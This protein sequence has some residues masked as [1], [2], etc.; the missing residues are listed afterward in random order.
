MIRKSYPLCGGGDGN[1]Y[2]PFAEY[3]Y[4]KLSDSG[5]CALVLPTGIV[6][7]KTYS[8]FISKLLTERRLISVYGFNSKSRIFKSISM[9]FCVL[10][11]GQPHANPAVFAFQLQS[12]SDINEKNTWTLNPKDITL[13]NPTTQTLPI[14]NGPISAQIVLKAH[15]R[16][17]VWQTKENNPWNIKLSTQFHMSAHSHLFWERS[18]LFDAGAHYNSADNTWELDQCLFYPLLEGKNIHQFC[19]NHQPVRYTRIVPK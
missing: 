3:S 8:P 12:I 18:A 10:T 19:S 2:G 13:C 7:D 1:L 15:Q 6:A 17:G 5:R 9:Q 14:F 4:H 16:F 11:F